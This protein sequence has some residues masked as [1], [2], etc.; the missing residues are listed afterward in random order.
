MI[1]GDVASEAGKSSVVLFIYSPPVD[2]PRRSSRRTDKF[3][4]DI[5]HLRPEYYRRGRLPPGLR[6]GFLVTVMFIG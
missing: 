1:V 3:P 5:C 4:P 2:E 6:L